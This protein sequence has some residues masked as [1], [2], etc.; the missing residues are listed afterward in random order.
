MAVGK[1]EWSQA[2]LREATLGK[3]RGQGFEVQYFFS[4]ITSFQVTRA[5]CLLLNDDPELPE[6]MVDPIQG[7]I[8]CSNKSAFHFP[9]EIFESAQWVKICLM[10]EQPVIISFVFNISLRFFHFHFFTGVDG[11]LQLC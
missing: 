11:S 2:G 8:Y 1:P 3:L 7:S 6:G 10:T 5:T 4:V 9:M